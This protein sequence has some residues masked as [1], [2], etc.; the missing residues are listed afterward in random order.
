MCFSL[1]NSGFFCIANPVFTSRLKSG[2]FFLFCSDENAPKMGLLIVILSLIFMKGNVI[3]ECRFHFHSYLIYCFLGS[4]ICLLFSFVF[5]QLLFGKCW[6]DY[7]LTVLGNIGCSETALRDKF[8]Y[9]SVVGWI[10][11]E[12]L[13]C[14][15]IWDILFFFLQ[16]KTQN[17]WWCEKAGD[18]GICEAK[19]SWGLQR[20]CANFSARREID[21]IGFSEW[22]MGIQMFCLSF[23]G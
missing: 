17:L 8:K 3:K 9:F 16:G 7:I 6:G 11:E 10:R 20:L 12:N 18:R 14:Q 22:Q 5:M 2:I 1:G 4:F 23:N 19:V 15:L 13:L 21:Y